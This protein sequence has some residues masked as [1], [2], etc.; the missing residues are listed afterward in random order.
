MIFSSPTEKKDDANRFL[1]TELI[2]IGIGEIRIWKEMVQ[3]DD[4]LFAKVYGLISSEN[5]RIAWHAAWIIDHV[6]EADPKKLQPYVSDLVKQL[7]NLKNSSLKRHFTRMLLGQQIPY[8]QLGKLIDV[9]YEL[10][11]PTEAVA[12]RANA[13][14]LLYNISMIERE[15][16]QELIVVTESILEEELTPGMNSK[17]RN[18]LSRLKHQ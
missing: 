6:S 17:A 10:L 13:L 12:V 15:L 2:N 4:A 3:Q 5:P 14:Q 16:Q 7:P 8:N 9:L 1:D 11:L 18:I